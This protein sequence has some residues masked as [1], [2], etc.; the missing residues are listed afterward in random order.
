M[1]TL[2]AITLIALMFTVYAWYNGRATRGLLKELFSKMDERTLKM[3]ER[4]ERRHSDV[5]ETLKQQHRDVIE[6]SEQRHLEIVE[7]L[8]L[9]EKRH[10][11]VMKAL[12]KGFGTLIQQRAT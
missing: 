11:E 12:E 4:A 10:E 3:D 1:D 5:M 6:T 8:K 7:L 9:G 2:T